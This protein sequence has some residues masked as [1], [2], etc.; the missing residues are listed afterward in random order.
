[1]RHDK[2]FEKTT[3]RSLDKWSI[4]KF[5]IRPFEGFAEKLTQIYAAE[6]IE[7]DTTYTRV[8]NEESQPAILF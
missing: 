4:Q 7:K 6:L 2:S 8:R 5:N 3:R 1:M